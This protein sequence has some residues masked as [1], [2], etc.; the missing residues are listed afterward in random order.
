MALKDWITKVFLIISLDYESIFLFF[1]L[2][3]DSSLQTVS[4]VQ[5]L[6]FFSHFYC[7]CKMVYLKQVTSFT[8]SDPSANQTFPGAANQQMTQ[9]SEESAAQTENN[10][11]SCS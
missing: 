9:V 2:F 8:A 4:I 1:F 10:K 11:E 6:D 7:V 3:K 5:C